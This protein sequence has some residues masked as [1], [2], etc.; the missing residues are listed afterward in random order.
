VAIY[1]P[2]GK[3]GGEVR[4]ECGSDVGVEEDRVDGVREL[5]L[6]FAGEL[7]CGHVAAFLSEKLAA[8]TGT[9][10]RRDRG[11]VPAF[12]FFAGTVEPAAFPVRGGEGEQAAAGDG[13][14]RPGGDVE[15]VVDPGRF[16]EHDQCD[17]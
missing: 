1:Q 2:P 14:H 7:G 17:A 9:L 10:A 6:V 12:S 11:L 8:D 16:V 4:V 5:A 3:R 15:V 13:E